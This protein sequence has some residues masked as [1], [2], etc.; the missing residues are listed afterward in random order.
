MRKRTSGEDVGAVSHFNRKPDREKSVPKAGRPKSKCDNCRKNHNK[1]QRC[2]AYGTQCKKC[3]KF[4]HLSYT[5]QSRSIREADESDGQDKTEEVYH[6][7]VCTIDTVNSSPTD[8]WYANL[9]VHTQKLK[10]RKP[11]SSQILG[12]RSVY[13]ILIIGLGRS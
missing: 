1:G 2:P 13:A 4:N 3:N 9:K 8:S 6:G 11:G 10:G 5:C 7:E 12:L